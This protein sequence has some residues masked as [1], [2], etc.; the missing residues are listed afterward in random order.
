MNEK[1]CIFNAFFL[2]L[3]WDHFVSAKIKHWEY[4]YTDWIH[5]KEAKIL[6][7]HFENLVD[8]LEWNLLRI[9]EFLDLETDSQRL[10]CVLSNGEGQFHR[11]SPKKATLSQIS[12]PFN[13]VQKHL[14]REAV[15]R[16]D[17][18]LKLASKETIP[19]HK[20]EFFS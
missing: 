4:F 19:I 5:S 6:V 13:N 7:V 2:Y 15:R 17:Q 1:D 11:R 9:L 8:N 20:Y 12:D 14:I 18:A 10:E 3:G 16:V